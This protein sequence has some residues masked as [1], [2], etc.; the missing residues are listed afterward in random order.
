MKNKPTITIGV[1]AFQGRD[2]IEETL[3]SIQQQTHQEFQV[4]V[5]IDGTDPEVKNLCQPFLSDSRFHLFVQPQRIGCVENLNWLMQK[6][7]TPF[8]CFQGQDDLLHP[9]YLETLLSEA[10]RQPKAAVVYS[11][12]TAFGSLH[13]EIVQPSVTGKTVS[14]QFYLLHSHHS[15][16]ALRGLTRL[17]ALQVANPIRPNEIEGFSTDTVWMAAM[18]RWGELWRVPLKLYRKRYHS[19]NEHGKWLTW[20]S[21]QFKKAWVTHCADMLEQ[22]LHTAVTAQEARL[23]WLGTLIR[24]ISA[25]RFGYTRHL[26]KNYSPME[27]LNDLTEHI[28]EKKRI[29][30]PARLE[31]NW[32]R[33]IGNAQ[34]L[35]KSHMAELIKY[36]CQIE[37]RVRAKLK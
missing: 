23:L 25:H 11:D 4:L 14:R 5:S 8:F 34:I 6:T 10:Q 2:F 9:M 27:L 30:L 1:P 24:L 33:I 15:A 12:I 17:E 29:E 37:Y 20:G 22:A 19:N 16:V 32:S 35:Y 7:D 36:A 26:L 31:Q 18:A 28:Q 13:G 21:E 3:H